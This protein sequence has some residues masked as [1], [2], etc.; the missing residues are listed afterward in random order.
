[1][2][3]ALKKR[4]ALSHTRPTETLLKIVKSFTSRL[5]PMDVDLVELRNQLL[6]LCV[7]LLIYSRVFIYVK[8]VWFLHMVHNLVEHLLH[9]QAEHNF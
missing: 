8:I 4:G 2:T 7:Y 5:N 1:M 6:V 9:Q 3:K